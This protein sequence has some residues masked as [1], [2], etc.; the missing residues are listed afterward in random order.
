MVRPCCNSSGSALLT[1]EGRRQL[2]EA[3]RQLGNDSFEERESASKRLLSRGSAA[4]PFLQPAR[5]AADPEVAR[6]AE[7][8]LDQIQNGSEPALLA[9]A[10]RELAR[11]RSAGA[12]P[13]LLHYTPFAL[14]SAEEDVLSA[15]VSLSDRMIR[16]EPALS[17]ALLDRLPARRAAAAYVLG[18]HGDRLQRQPVL[19]LL[20]DPEARVR[21]RAA[22]GL[23]AGGERSAV[24]A[25]I[26]LLLEAP[27]EEGSSQALELLERLAGEQSPDLPL[28]PTPESRKR[29]QAAWAGWW[30]RHGGKVDIARALERPSQLGLTLAL[31]GPNGR[32]WEWGRDG[33]IRWEIRATGPMDAQILP[34]NRILIAEANAGRVT[35]R[36]L[37]GNILWEHKVPGEPI[38]CRRLANGNTFIGT[39]NSVMEVTP[40]GKVAA[41][42]QLIVGGYFHGVG[43]TSTGH[44]LYISSTGEIGEFDSAGKQLRK[45]QLKD[46]GRWGE[47]I[48]D[49]PGRYLVTNY[50]T[51]KVLQINTD[52]KLL[53]EK[54]VPASCGV[55]RLANGHLLIG[56]GSKVVVLDRA[57]KIVQELDVTGFA[58]RAHRR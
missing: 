37:K 19:K 39:R 15:L 31:D 46:E 3:I 47:V 17:A 12:I 48:A 53:W 20:T 51:G 23:L 2:Q 55:E 50:G 16:P 58:R 36:D 25:L 11:R 4:V 7:E 24:P 38:N 57:G 32:V 26:R 43:R 28:E 8:I 56:A 27:E 6:R 49:G 14:P 9:A 40:A 18:R 45:I 30:D 33:K 54:N 35:E 34:G 10:A 13:V 41:S 5:Q 42:H 44:Y 1:E 29:L 21:L 22:Q 52:G